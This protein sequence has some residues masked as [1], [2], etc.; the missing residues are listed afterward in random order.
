MGSSSAGLR[1][2]D[3]GNAP[4][5]CPAR[6]HLPPCACSHGA[7]RAA[8]VTEIAGLAR[9]SG[10]LLAQC[11]GITAGFHHGQAGEARHLRAARLCIEAGADA[12]R[13]HRW[14][15]EGRRRAAARSPGA[16]AVSWPGG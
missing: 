5:A 9:G 16:G 12:A 4:P 11:A 3:K 2:A 7:G 1:Q 10:D 13:V 14:A 8:A 15:G 6:A